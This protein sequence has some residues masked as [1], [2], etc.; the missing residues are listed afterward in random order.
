MTV[1]FAQGFLTT[2]DPFTLPCLHLVSRHFLVVFDHFC[3][4]YV[5]SVTP[6]M[7]HDMVMVSRVLEIN[8][9]ITEE[10]SKTMKLQITCLYQSETG[11]K[12]SFNQ[13]GGPFMENI[14]FDRV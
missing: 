6:G 10:I 11:I 5:I 8:C 3:T 13:A 14:G 4:A 9:G 7:L 2:H 12:I 1:I